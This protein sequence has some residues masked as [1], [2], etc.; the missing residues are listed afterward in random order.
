ML[1]LAGAAGLARSPDQDAGGQIAAAAIGATGLGLLGSAAFRTDPVNGYPPGTPDT[2][3]ET[4]ATGAMHTVAGLPIFLG[5]PAA[6]LACA[7]RFYRSGR[8]G[9]AAYSTA[10]GA[11]ILTTMGLSSAGLSQALRLVNHAGLFQ[12]AAIVTG[13]SWLTALSVR[14]RLPETAGTA[15]AS[16][17]GQR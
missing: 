15:A 9:W 16:L 3:A 17:P 1:Y 8:A 7:W 13:F 14:A 10:T 4:S 2:P 5:I 12:R 6:A 11:S